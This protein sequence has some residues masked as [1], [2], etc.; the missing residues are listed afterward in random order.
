MSGYPF[1]VTV[2]VKR[3]VYTTDR[4]NNQIA[5]GYTTIGFIDGAA[6]A[7][8]GD[9]TL[10]GMGRD[11]VDL[12]PTLYIMGTHDVQDKDRCVIDGIEYDVEGDPDNWTFVWGGMQRMV[13]KLKCGGR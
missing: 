7:P 5:S 3:P 1:G 11:G 6:F 4:Y 12:L 9:Q 10:T 8:N 13:I 2:E